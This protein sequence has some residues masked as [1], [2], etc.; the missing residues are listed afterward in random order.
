MIFGKSPLEKAIDQWSKEGGKLDDFSQS[1]R[2]QPVRSKSEA[3]AICR[4]LDSL[5]L[6]ENTDNQDF[7]SSLHTLVAFF[8]QVDSEEA[9]EIFV[10][11][12]LPCLRMW[13][14]DGVDGK[15]VD[16]DNLLFIMKILA[17]YREREDVDL[18]ARAARKPIS[19]DGFMWSIIFGQFG[20]EHPFANEMVDALRDP[21]PT[22]FIL[23]SYLDMAN[24]LAIAGTLDQHPFD[25][26]A[27]LT[28]LQSW[29]TDTD[30]ENFSYALSST[31]A[32]P[33]IDKSA[34]EKLLQTAFE[35]PD[36][37]VRME[38]AWAEAKSG[39]PAGVERL[40][41]L[42]LDPRFSR[43]A[44]QYLQQ[45]GLD[46]V[47]PGEAKKAAFQAV[48]EMANWLAHP[49]EFGRPP[50][51]IELF[52]VRELFWPPTN[53]NR[54]VSLVKY[55]YDDVD[56]EPEVGVG[57]VGSVTFALFGQATAELLPEDIYALHCCWE[58]EMNDDPRAPENRTAEGG[59]KIL[60]QFN[61]GF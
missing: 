33:F 17:M 53:D 52:D 11:V 21:L 15:H 58:L 40:S 5:R 43:T 7:W 6:R 55:S 9:L 47:I 19:S 25:S 8:Q 10:Q 39:D 36:P 35:H 31:A 48:A 16:E 50:D 30:E 18:I 26:N 12:G 57:M 1:S 20:S 56:G 27:G 29:L 61:K 37:S 2:N 46:D 32:L 44:Q 41:E 49:S 51:A 4:A 23:I 54:C 13:I 14:R 34:C 60:A 3:K 45:L 38:A 22:G 59:R 42:C 28:H 24:A